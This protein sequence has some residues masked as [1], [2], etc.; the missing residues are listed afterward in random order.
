MNDELDMQQASV[1]DVDMETTLG[2]IRRALAEEASA[3][4]FYNY[5]Y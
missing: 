3:E 1:F 2:L 4:K 5:L